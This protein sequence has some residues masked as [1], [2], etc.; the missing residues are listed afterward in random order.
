MTFNIAAKATG[1]YELRDYQ[2]KT[3]PE[4]LSCTDLF[5]SAPTGAGK[6]L[7]FQL[8]LYAFD[9][10]LGEGCKTIVFVIVPLISI[11]KGL[12]SSLNCR[13]ITASYVG[14]NILK[15][16]YTFVLLYFYT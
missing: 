13:G 8:V 12:V 10:L 1:Y 14:D 2:R 5:V 11:T 9:R 7:T 6:S 4:Y 16:F 3:I 15:N